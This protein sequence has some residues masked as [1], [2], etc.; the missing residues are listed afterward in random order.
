MPSFSMAKARGDGLG[1][2]AMSGMSRGEAFLVLTGQNDGTNI[3][4]VGAAGAFLEVNVAG[5]HSQPGGEIARFALDG[6]HLGVGQDLNVGVAPD[7]HH[8]GRHNAH[9]TVVRRERLVQL[10]HVAA[11][12]A[13]ALHQ[14]HLNA[15]VGQIEGSLHASDAATDNHHRPD[16]AVAGVLIIHI[17]NATRRTSCELVLLIM[18]AASSF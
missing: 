3:G 9:G 5:L 17:V 10:R 16:R 13:L 14:V 8:L 7:V 18:F 1:V 15:C 2:Q 6:T 4:T 11:D 12:G